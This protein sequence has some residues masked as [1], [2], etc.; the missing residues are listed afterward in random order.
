MLRYIEYG[1]LAKLLL[2][3]YRVKPS[4]WTFTW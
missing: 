1:Q 2:I 3:G 4:F